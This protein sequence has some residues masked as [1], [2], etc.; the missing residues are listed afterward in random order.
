MESAHKKIIA[1]TFLYNNGYITQVIKK[2][3][4]CDV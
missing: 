4:V 1:P 3:G 2:G